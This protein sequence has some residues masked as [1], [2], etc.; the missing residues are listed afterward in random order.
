MS[1]RGWAPGKIVKTLR[2]MWS[3]LAERWAGNPARASAMQNMRVEHGIV[4]TRPG[5]SAVSLATDKVSGP[6][7]NWVTPTG[8]NLVLYRDGDR[9]LSYNQGLNTYSGIAAGLNANNTR[10]PSFA[11][12]DVWTYFCGQDAGGIGTFQT[13]IFDG[14]NV[15]V[16][17]RPSVILTAASATDVGA[18]QCTIGTHLFGFVYQTRNGF[19]GRPST[20]VAG[21]AISVVLG[22]DG[23][24]V[25]I[26]VTLPALG[27]GGLS[28]T[29]GVSATLFLIA[30]RADDP[31][32]WFFIS[33]DPVSGTIGSRPVP[34]NAPAT[35]AFVMNVSDAD[36]T[37]SADSAADNFLFF[38][39]AADGTGPFFPGFVVA[40]GQRM[41]YG[42]GT[43]LLVS[44]ANNPQQ[45]ALDQAS[46][47]MPSQ[48]KMGF[49]FPLQGSTE[50]YITGERWTART[51]D[52]SD[53]P[54]TWAQPVLVSDALGAP[55]PGCV[56]Y[57]TGGRYA[58]IVTENGPYLFDG[59][60]GTN[61]LTYLIS[62]IDAEGVPLG[63]ARVNWTAA[64][65]IQCADDVKNLKL[66][67]AAPLDGATDPTHLF[68]IDY[69]NGKEFDTCDISLDVITDR[70]TI[71]GIGV[72]KEVASGLSN[73]WIGPPA[74][75]NVVHF[76][77]L[78]R[79]DSGLAIDNFW[80]SGL[81]RS[82]SEIQSTMIRV[83]FL[84]MWMR[85]NSPLVGG[86]SH[87]GLAIKGPDQ[88]VFVTPEIQIQMGIPASLINSPG[89][90]YGAKFDLSQIE[91]FTVT[92]RTNAVD[93]WFELSGFRA[94]F[95]P[96][97]FNR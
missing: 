10:S 80:Q 50:L 42:A 17:F 96:D 93:E 3:A 14:L 90:M 65:A 11:D 37:A 75:G 66:Y 4:R 15:D 61:P 89:K 23:R 12:V 88:Q 18:G 22:T 62:G 71:P 69:R 7:F 32:N 86:Q 77:I 67:I 55:F 43:V 9:V 74:A 13:K 16:A 39:Q 51:T 92:F 8:Q 28:A 31:A 70:A 20:D 83:G 33:N 54:A 27:D 2:G 64:Y 25:N 84:D 46:V 45:I 5:T 82:T 26:S 24:T 68:V 56:A 79:N 81:V 63:W 76:D 52:T 72:V 47:T 19:S 53:I 40:Y 59:A 48:R 38:T 58:W 6:I 57:K 94:Y 36:I 78:T 35:L 30:T 44:P 21:V 91:N 95:K 41:C 97:L 60:F 87:F 1:I 73:L 49:A 34:F 29:G 85:G